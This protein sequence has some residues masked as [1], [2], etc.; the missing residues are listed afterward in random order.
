VTP[1]ARGKRT[2][3]PSPDKFLTTPEVARIAVRNG[4]SSSLVGGGATESGGSVVE[5]GPAGN[6]RRK[7]TRGVERTLP[8]L[9]VDSE[10][11]TEGSVAQQSSVET[12]VVVGQ[13][14]QD[15]PIE[16]SNSPLFLVGPESS[17]EDW[18]L[19][20]ELDPTPKP[21]PK[22]KALGKR[23]APPPIDED[24]G[25]EVDEHLPP[26]TPEPEDRDFDAEEEEGEQ[27]DD[28][29]LSSRPTKRS[30]KSS[31]AT[32]SKPKP[33]PRTT[34]EDSEGGPS[35]FPIIVHRLS[36]TQGSTLPAG[37]QRSGVN[38]VDVISQVATEIID[39]LYQ[40]LR[41]GAEKKAVEIFKEELNLRFLELVS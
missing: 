25:E 33:R 28:E 18:E 16:K 32:R 41:A 9:E 26:P 38:P 4:R 21:Q 3:Q 30:A 2:R 20:P 36:K 37:S 8:E 31:I 22:R 11:E 39:K 13:E 24:E 19:E 10:D 27:E 1:V 40:K 5:K 17:G 14:V 7:V 12:T 15:K 34:D 35:T 6:K 29:E 23:P